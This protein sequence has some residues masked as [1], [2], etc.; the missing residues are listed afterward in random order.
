[1][2]ACCAQFVVT[3]ETVRGR[4]REEYVRF[5]QYLIDTELDDYFSGRVFERSWHVVF[6]KRPV[7]CEVEKECRCQVYTGPLG[8]GH[9]WWKS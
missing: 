4:S 6:G 8:C 2:A 9:G 1:M 5:R 3:G 7:D